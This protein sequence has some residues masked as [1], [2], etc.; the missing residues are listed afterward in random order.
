MTEKLVRLEPDPITPTAIERISTAQLRR[1]GRRSKRA[2]RQL[3]E[4]EMLL[5]AEMRC[6]TRLA[7]SAM[8]NYVAGSTWEQALVEFHPGSIA[9]LGTFTAQLAHRLSDVLRQDAEGRST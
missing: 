3:Y 8:A 5:R 2:I 7:L 9:A 6:E 4:R 1:G